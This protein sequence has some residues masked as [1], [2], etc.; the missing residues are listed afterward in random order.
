[1]PPLTFP[2]FNSPRSDTEESH[3]LENAP[4]DNQVESRVVTSPPDDLRLRDELAAAFPVE[5]IM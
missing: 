5:G 1:M 4:L 3:P 2:L